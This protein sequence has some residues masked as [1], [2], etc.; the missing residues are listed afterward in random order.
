MIGYAIK[1]I[2]SRIFFPLPLVTG[3]LILGIGIQRWTRWKRTGRCM[4]GAGLILLVIFGYNIGTMPVLRSIERSYPSL[5]A[6]MIAELPPATDILV[7]GQGLAD[8][9]GLPA[10]SRIG[11]T[12]LARIVESVRVHRMLPDSRIFI[13]VAGYVSIEDKQTFLDEL[14]D[15]LVVERD[16]FILLAGARDTDD[17]LNLVL[18]QFEGSSLVLVSS[19][20]HLPRAMRMF[21][22]TD[23][24]VI[25]SPCGYSAFYPT[26]DAPWSPLALFP[27]A[28]QMRVSENAIYELLGN[29]WV[30]LRA[31][32]KNAR[33]NDKTTNGQR[34]EMC[35]HISAV[36]ERQS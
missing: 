23:I 14:A 33:S 32:F 28:R 1:K 36:Q 35:C 8:E 11:E 20:S 5:T 29:L 7:L 6:E 17:E 19:A 22:A 25:P 10:N 13:S 2:V 18:E 21:A 24:D 26:E 27:S 9:P 3:L 16:A 4:V 15:M 12:Y 31:P 34:A 30:R